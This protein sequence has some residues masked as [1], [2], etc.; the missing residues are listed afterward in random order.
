MANKQHLIH[1]EK[2]NNVF[3]LK[4][5]SAC[6]KAV[7]AGGVFIGSVAPVQAELPIA[8]ANW[9]GSG[10]ATS[11][12]VGNNLNIDQ[13]SQNAILNWNS[14]NVSSDSAVNFRQP[15]ASSIALNRI[16]DVNPSQI[17]GTV[18]AN[19]QIYLV[20]KNG[21][22]FGRDSVVNAHGLVA[23]TLDV[24]Q[25]AIDNGIS[26]VGSEVNPSAAFE[27]SGEFY[28]DD[29]GVKVPIKIDIQSGAQIKSA[30][31]GRI[32]VLAPT[33]LNRGNVESSGGQV[34]MAAATDKV[35]LQEASTTAN[36]DVRGLLVEVATGGKVENL[37]SISSNH[38][39]VTLMGFAVNQKGTV[40][41]TTTTNLNGTI[42]LLAREGGTIEPT[43]G[44]GRLQSTSTTRSVDNGDGLGVSA[45]V[46]LDKGSRTE[47]LPEIEYIEE[48][49]T[50]ASGE[51][52][53]VLVEKSAIDKQAQ[54]QSRVEIMA[55]TVHLKSGSEIVAPHGNVT[56]T[57][58]VSPTTPVVI[59]SEK[60][61]SRIL[62][63]S[64][65]TIDVSGTDNVV[66]TMESNI[67]EVELRN[68]ELKDAPLQKTG[69]LKGKTVLVDARE[70]TPLTDIQPFLD[71]IK[72][73]IDERLVKGGEISLQSEG[74]VILEKGAVL[75]FSGGAVTYLDGI[76]T[77][78]KLVAN[79]RLIDISQA[80]PL[81]TYTGIYGEVVKNYAK[82][83][84]TKTWK[85][86]GPFA[87][88]RFEQ[89]YVQGFDAGS[90]SIKGHNIVLDGELLGNAINGRR[91]RSL[92]DQA[93][94]GNLTVNNG[95]TFSTVQDLIFSEQ[96]AGRVDL[97]KVVAEELGK[98][99]VINR[100]DAKLPLTADGFA[101]ALALKA[102]KLVDSG[103]REAT[104]ISNGKIVI[105]DNATLKLVDGGIL[106][107]KGGAIDVLGNIQGAG[108]TVVLETAK[109]DAL[110]LDG[111]ITVAE[112][113]RINL[114][115]EW[116]ND[117]ANPANLENKSL[118]INGGQFSATAG[119]KAGGEL[120][121][122]AGS[123]IDVS[124]GAW[125][126]TDRKLV[127]GTAG[128][129]TL[130]AKPD[131]A[132]NTGS[133]VIMDGILKAYGLEKGGRFTAEANEVVIRKEELEPGSER[134]QPLQLTNDFFTKG[135]FAEYDI[136]SNM[137]G[138]TV[139]A[140]VTLNLQQ[141]NLV[142]NEDYL[143][144][145][146]AVDLGELSQIATLLPE[147]RASSKL[148]LEA[149]HSAG[150]NA[151]SHLV[152][153]D[154]IINA[155]DLSSVT[156]KSD[157][158]LFFDGKIN[159]RGGD[160]ALIITPPK[161]LR[162]D[163]KFQAAQGIWL[164][165]TAK[166][167]VSGSSRILVDN[168][169]HRIGDVFD[170]GTVNVDAQRGFFASQADSLINVSGSQGLLDLPQND[171]NSIGVKYDAT[172]IGSNAG[173]IGIAAAEGI[174]I[175]GQ[176][177]A[178][179]GDAPGTDGGKLSLMLN[180]Q[181][182]IDPDPEEASQ[183]HPDT[184]RII[185]V[186]Q[187]KNS[188]FSAPFQKAGDAQPKKLL[189]KG[190]LAASQIAEGGFSSLAIAVSNADD[191]VHFQDNVTLQL[192]NAIALSAVKFGWESK[193]GADAGNAILNAT[194]VSIG[195][196]SPFLEIPKIDTTN[197]GGQLTVN[198]D[199]IDLVGAS[200]TTGFNTVNLLANDDIRLRGTKYSADE[201]KF[202][203]Q[204]K[205][206]SKLNLT[207]DQIYPT[208]LSSFTLAVS[209][210][211]LGTVTFNKGDGNQPVLSALG[212]L[213]VSAPNIVQNGTI[214]APFGEIALEAT[215]TIKLGAN[216]LTSVSAE[217]QIIPLGITQGGQEWLLPL[218]D[219]VGGNRKPILESPQ[220]K[221][222][223]KADKILRDDGALVD[224]SGGGDLLAYEFIPGSGGS[225]D[226]LDS[227]QSFAVLPGVT[228]YAPFDFRETPKSGLKTGDSIFVSGGSGLAE[229]NYALLPAR[230]AMLP[231]AFLVTPETTS[232]DVIPGSARTRIDGASIVSGYGTVAGT[233][234][235]DQRWSE[236]VIEPGSIAN[237]RS[238]YNINLASSF[239]AERAVNNEQAI[240]RLTQDAGQVVFN[241][242]SQLDLPTVIA[243]AVNGGRGGLVDIVADKLSVVT[244][245]T[246][247][248]GVV[249]LLAGDI[250]KL[251]VES[252]LLGGVRSFD[253][254]TDN[255][256]LDVKAKSVT[257]AENTRVKAPELMLAATDK[258]ELKR[259]A[260]VQTDGTV[261]DSG[262]DTVLEV[263]GDGA[264]LR[265]SAGKQ[266][267]LK[268]T[269]TNETKGDLL[270]NEGAVIAAGTGSVLLESTRKSTLDGELELAGGSLSLGAKA[271]NLGDVSGVTNGLSLDNSQLNKLTLKELVLTSRSAV[272]LYGQIGKADLN[273]NLVPV[274]FG[275]LVIDAAGLSGWQNAG[276]TALLNAK[277][278]TFINNKDVT[279]IAGTGTG[280][281]NI[282]AEQLVLDKGNYQ[283]SGFGQ[284][285][286]NMSDSVIG[287]GVGQLTALSDVT[288]TTP[289]VSAA[290][291]AKTTIDATDH[292][293]FFNQSTQ[294]LTATTQGI[295]AQLKLIADSVALNTALLYKTGNVS[296]DAL[297]GDVTLG[298]NALI[299]VSG[300]V[301]DAGLSKPVNLSAG[302]INLSSQQRNVLA[303]ANS[304]LLLNG[305][306][307]DMQA[308]L[309]SVQAGKGQ[310]QL[311][312]KVDAHGIGKANGGSIAMDT[313]SLTA[314][315][316]D[317]L[318]SLFSTAGFTGGIDLRLHNGD[319]SVDA[320]QTV[321]AVTIK[322]TADTGKITV[323]GTLDATG[324]NGGTVNLA[325]EDAL[326]L[327]ASASI[328]AN[329]QGVD[330]NGG[331][332][333]LSSIEQDSDGAGI[334][335]NS[336]ARI[337]VAAT[338][339]GKEGEVHL[340][341]DR[342]DTDNDGQDDDVN[343]NTIASGA[344]TGDSDVTVEAAKI[345]ND[346]SIT[347]ADQDVYH[348]DNQSY[349]AKLVE[350][351]VADTRFGS[352]FTIMP[353]VE[354]QSD[355]NLTIA[356]AWD[357]VTWRYDTGKVNNLTG[358]S[359]FTPGILTLRAA[360]NLLIEKNLSDA[361]AQGQIDMGA[362][363][364]VTTID[365]FLQSGRSWSY[366]LVAG[367]D[368]A[369]ADSHAL[370]A[371]IG[372][373][374]LGDNIDNVTVRTGTGDIDI[375]AGHDIE[376]LTNTD[377]TKNSVVYTAGRPDEA[378]RYGFSLVLTG[379]TFYAEYPL[380]G[381]DIN[382]QA[383]QDIIG[384]PTTQLV[385]DWLVRTGTW[386]G[387]PDHHE[388]R[389]TA[390]GI[391]FGGF[392][393]I[394]GGA[395][396]A[397]QH[398]QSVAAF[399]GGNV[400]INAGRDVNDL[401]V[402]IPTTG[403]QVGVKKPTEDQTD[404][405]YLTN[406]V[407]INGGGN[408]QLRAGGDVSGGM[409]YVDGS[410]GKGTADLSAAGSFK[411]GT[412]TFYTDKGLSPIL[413]LGDSQFTVTAGKDIALEAIVD[414]M[415]IPQQQRADFNAVANQ[416]FRYSAD[417]AVKLTTLSGNITL[418]NDSTAFEKATGMDGT[419]LAVRIQPATLKAYAL[420][421]DIQ[422]NNDDVKTR[423]DF[424]LYPSA[425]GGLELFAANNIT[426]NGT[427]NQSDTDP[428]LLPS[429][430]NPASSIASFQ[431]AL[432][433]LSSIESTTLIHATTP[434]HLTDTD[435]VLISTGIGSIVGGP[436]LEFVLAKHAEV[437]AGKDILNTSFKIQH[438]IDDTNTIIQAGRDFRI[439][440]TIDPAT[441]QIDST[442]QGIEIAG[443]G[444]LTVLAN[445]NIDLG[446]SNG[447]N[448]IGNTVN[449]AL[450]DDGANIS[451]IAGLAGGQLNVS[452]FAE[453]FLANTDKY[454]LE[455]QH[456]LE[457]FVK[458][459]RVVTGNEALTV[460]TAKVAYNN[461]PASEKSRLEGKLLGSVQQVFFKELK[462]AGSKGASA[463]AKHVQDQAEL[464]LLAAV[465]TLFPGTTLLSDNKDYSVD[466]FKGVAAN[467]TTTATAILD[468]INATKL[469]RPVLGDISLPL[470][471]I[472]TV[473][474]GDVNLMTPNGG[475]TAGLPTSIVIA[476]KILNSKD[477][478]G[479]N[480][481][482]LDEAGNKINDPGQ[483][484]IIDKKTGD[485]NVVARNDFDV[486]TGRATTLGGGNVLGVSTEEDVDAGSS[487]KSAVSA[488]VTT[489][490]Y[491][492]NGLP[493]I[494][495]SPPQKGGGISA[496]S[497]PGIKDGDVSLFAF[498]GIIDAGEAGIAGKNVTLG[499]TAINGADNI[500]VG[501]VAVGV[502]VAPT[503]SIAA[504]LTGVSNLAASVTNAVDS[505]TNM[506]DDANK[507][508]A[509]AAL[510]ILSIDFLGFGD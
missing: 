259:G 452:G 257:I 236:Y 143:T 336:G 380:E 115:G 298:N 369:S 385:S 121:L 352:G 499:A 445:R 276:K 273:G 353:G 439:K 181:N 330:G 169:G 219:A 13:T 431:D 79:G 387:N 195:F 232:R 182:R 461:L 506:G 117:F 60:N 90:V 21:F 2:N 26:K 338:G 221:I 272:N 142:L 288:I 204:F 241:A 266:A 332:V 400:N 39:N 29:N 279:G 98:G 374:K 94:G 476:G 16:S 443:P 349:M 340:R 309:L 285:N 453:K 155:D 15:S 346:D 415:F 149:N 125:L 450:A 214:R 395:D 64:G 295:G 106:N 185:T 360:N 481:P 54:P 274:E 507:T 147:Q 377:G 105:D 210:D 243:D 334:A 56:V 390:W 245:K 123:L 312:G 81:F 341:A 114:Q 350:N 320:A 33:I 347:L 323:G 457:Q 368:L 391:A 496:N 88:G 386:S 289:F 319:I 148:T 31:G 163:P 468:K 304:R 363:F 36:S 71:G 459:M 454:A 483:L 413:A 398:Q 404:F 305:I 222:T 258:V 470:S 41:A 376:Y 235:R 203:G 129:I 478:D 211:P 313:G 504:G 10:S 162:L 484:G 62:V 225:T 153:S 127:A 441:G 287:R 224:L 371:G 5:L 256:K 18:T 131:K 4:P 261:A 417:S 32:M 292:Q 189:G 490:T 87:L 136:S 505:S 405:D 52:I 19:G 497:P 444:Q 402:V 329:A 434:V 302:K 408:L 509:N 192:D 188:S 118:A 35:Y 227:G 96:E 108:A 226:V 394:K 311:N 384:K 364:G 107:L 403:K 399:G 260:R 217:Q 388:E 20:N 152:F 397:M 126:Q 75:D 358:E 157:S 49:Q 207:A 146:N 324:V 466:P 172:L 158:S 381:G 3:K 80:D 252:L 187:E 69:L 7:I 218:V 28:R 58:T 382:L 432:S 132:I 359:V 318:N 303:D 50:L 246:G 165:N 223:V 278:V 493:I 200:V 174:F 269:G 112:G 11:A 471:T 95:F 100:L 234:I 160:I 508:L 249:E 130:S 104:F 426:G 362:E 230:Y 186:S 424:N 337:D 392:S 164:G 215:N 494:E 17:L 171:P 419:K 460:E 47:I 473:D 407:E 370:I 451:V 308:G 180:T 66:K 262:I 59:N 487:P 197:G 209:G 205:T 34:I 456:Y 154:A 74:D 317:G 447:I 383:G 495:V 102:G 63:E 469:D 427:I 119:G 42:R 99:N 379:S 357:L 455:N 406:K 440:V 43:Q 351:N 166:I 438:N 437:N 128:G 325:A 220:K 462:L 284:I 474:G 500:D 137:N 228:N 301:V 48:E 57:A 389:P 326:T 503:G 365:N 76:I 82:W 479:N 281:L 265:V 255:V 183:F 61:S 348:A 231:G 175:D 37:G 270:V 30:E 198:A 134:M 396:D 44:Q 141:A 196:D 423:R 206:F 194:T 271:I 356:D 491:D 331:K 277:K 116:V 293:L 167:D 177:R 414:P 299:D 475:V 161:S 67:L 343:I 307:A 78:T 173:T 84:V 291:G 378:N 297:Q 139:E 242:N 435:P 51:V 248:A 110:T 321:T 510:G 144:R 237:T 38:G 489:V 190:F 339:S 316:F 482:V 25:H 138:L 290:N 244:D 280:I 6:V 428:D 267:T 449:T 9:V 193:T 23:S 366:N 199:L 176:M 120:N 250:D 485:I 296:I 501:G 425:N 216:S 91:Q 251:K 208:S 72:R 140:G 420:N 201:L 24:T 45:R 122:K 247:A 367:S 89:G 393:A 55:N 361:F 492:N 92:D 322:L 327:E 40:S 124:G 101:V 416:F 477:S 354:V 464:E 458:E 12:V 314:G 412:N 145:A 86:D 433:R 97:D 229:G 83:G 480:K 27:G 465:E 355:G 111:D 240:P 418:E 178:K 85:I 335:I 310:V 498:R 93:K 150:E 446:A 448:S 156:L 436:D 345:Y 421:G 113:A 14:F 328:L 463:T 133:N 315:G 168:F 442:T 263:T 486:N 239:F 68:F 73:N 179:A 53:K 467:S 502:P 372:D 233:D 22:V 430:L 283:L 429:W 65:A 410:N 294:N 254:K 411:A 401:S 184:R 8:S 238:E 103:I 135:G 170:G 212:K 422:F 282:N 373:V 202:G 1:P 333:T 253:S 409:F 109:T 344:I 213:T 70:G 300:A 342:L 159:A 46:T 472:Q 264:L 275:N 488:S 77:T 191:E 268:R 286:L 306:N 375:R 151:D